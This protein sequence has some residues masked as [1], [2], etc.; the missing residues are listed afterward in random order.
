MKQSINCLTRNANDAGTA[1]PSVEM[2]GRAKPFPTGGVLN[3]G[4]TSASSV[5]PA[6]TPA[7][8]AFRPPPHLRCVHDEVQIGAQGQV[9]EAVSQQVHV[10]R[11]AGAGLQLPWGYRWRRQQRISWCF[12]T[13]WKGQC[14]QLGFDS[15][16]SLFGSSCGRLVMSVLIVT[17][18]VQPVHPGCVQA[19]CMT[20]PFPMTVFPAWHRPTV[21]CSRKAESAA[22]GRG[23]HCDAWLGAGCSCAQLG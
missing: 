2:H 10:L 22:A 9:P 13:A 1:G 21:V 16:G 6:I 14:S 20:S 18:A 4:W 7:L 3:A 15:Y 12:C 5:H 17:A 11:D 23:N 19:A 8:P